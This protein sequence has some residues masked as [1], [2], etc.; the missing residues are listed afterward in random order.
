MLLF[1]NKIYKVI[2]K[3][4]NHGIVYSL[5]GPGQEVLLLMFVPILSLVHEGFYHLTWVTVRNAKIGYPGNRGE[6][7][8]LEL[9]PF[10][11]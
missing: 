3:H 11:F 1:S 5:V 6:L 7:K 8:S 2:I 9:P 10:L 4:G